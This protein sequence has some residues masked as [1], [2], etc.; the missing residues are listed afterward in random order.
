MNHNSFIRFWRG[1]ML[2]GLALLLHGWHGS[3]QAP[4]LFGQEPLSPS[5]PS[6]VADPANS[7]TPFDLTDG[8]APVSGAPTRY[9]SKLLQPG[10]SG[11]PVVP[12]V[13]PREFGKIEPQLLRSAL[14]DELRGAHAKKPYR[15]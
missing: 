15:F 11:L 12:T 6:V 7:R 5:Q 4:S 9:T 14:I 1:P 13:R 8:L 2:G 10:P 3:G